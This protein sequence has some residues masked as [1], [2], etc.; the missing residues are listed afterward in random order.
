METNVFIS[1]GRTSTPEQEEFVYSFEQFLI[2]NGFTP[3]TVGRTDFSSLQPLKFI[4]QL[5]KQCSGTVVIA[6]ERI[7]IQGGLERRGSGT[8]TVIRN[9]NIPTVWNH[10]EAGMAYVLGHPLLVIAEQGLRIEGVLESDHDW[11]IQWVD[12]NIPISSNREFAG[13]FTDWKKQ[14]NE[15]NQTK[16]VKD[17]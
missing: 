13:I 7:H 9:E 12:I 8:K 14:V 10:I 16:E 1:V 4:K 3:R 6:F 5:M 2:G 15:Y 17:D 11:Y